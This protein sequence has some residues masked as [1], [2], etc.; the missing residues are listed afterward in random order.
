[1]DEKPISL[2]LG[3]TPAED[4]PQIFVNFMFIPTLPIPHKKDAHILFAN[5]SFSEIY[6]M[7]EQQHIGRFYIPP[8]DAGVIPDDTN[9]EK[10]K[11]FT[12]IVPFTS[13]PEILPVTF[14]HRTKGKLWNIFSIAKDTGPLLETIA[15]FVSLLNQFNAG[16]INTEE[17]RSLCHCCGAWYHEFEYDQIINVRISEE[18]LPTR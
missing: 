9:S 16:E 18:D 3:Y 13:M 8:F 5:F 1:M 12:G 6:D 7:I 4:D 2:I 14:W 15:E 17:A 11:S 10:K